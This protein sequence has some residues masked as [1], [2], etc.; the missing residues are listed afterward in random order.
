MSFLK[1]NGLNLSITRN[2]WSTWPAGTF[3]IESFQWVELIKARKTPYIA[4]HT[5]F[6][7]RCL[8][9]STDNT[10]LILADYL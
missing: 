9:H 4:N 10:L 1:G 7:V 8:S 5:P 2:A 3:D 6:R